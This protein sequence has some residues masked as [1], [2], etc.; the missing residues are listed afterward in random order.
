MFHYMNDTATTSNNIDQQS[1]ITTRDS[2]RGLK[3]KKRGREGFLKRAKK[4]SSRRRHHPTK[5][6]GL[7]STSFSSFRMSA[8]EHFYSFRCFSQ[9][10][11]LKLCVQ[12]GCE[13]VYY[14]STTIWSDSLSRASFQ[15]GLESV[16]RPFTNATVNRSL[17]WT[18]YKL[19]MSQKC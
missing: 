13:T 2:A 18:T 6:G 7:G 3:K 5:K 4:R 1:G 12:K 8:E 19:T 9:L 10:F 17:F 15:P 14:C 16:H 11:Q